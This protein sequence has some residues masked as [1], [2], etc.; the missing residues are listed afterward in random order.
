[1]LCVLRRFALLAGCRIFSGVSVLVLPSR[2]RYVIARLP[3]VVWNAQIPHIVAPETQV[4]GMGDEAAFVVDPADPEAWRA[5]I[6][7]SIDSDSTE[8]LPSGSQAS[9]LGLDSGKGKV[10]CTCCPK[11]LE[12]V[13]TSADVQRAF[14]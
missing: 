3:H 6:F 9:A 14:N 13:D 5:Q 2:E 7:R 8:G 11:L 12:S 4:R 1:M 10:S